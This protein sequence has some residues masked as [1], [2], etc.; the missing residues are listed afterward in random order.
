MPFRQF[1]A[2]KLMFYGQISSAL[3]YH[4]LVCSETQMLTRLIACF[5][6]VFDFRNTMSFLI[7]VVL[8]VSTCF[9]NH[10]NNVNNQ[11]SSAL[12]FLDDLPSVNLVATIAKRF[13][14]EQ[15]FENDFW[16]FGGMCQ[17]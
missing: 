3:R 10:R 5:F 12:C 14:K 6:V 1:I 4:S 16:C 2:A 9:L 15:R 17:N 8:I 11:I 13:A 7:C